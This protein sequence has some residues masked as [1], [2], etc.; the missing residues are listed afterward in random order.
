MGT[1]G[2]K[3]ISEQ[4][5][6]ATNSAPRPGAFPL[7]SIESR[8][9]ARALAWRKSGKKEVLRVEVVHIAAFRG[10]LPSSSRY[11]C[12]NCIIELIHL[13][14]EGYRSPIA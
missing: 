3:H 7:G 6:P 14:S 2:K 1:I 10:D 4:A 5:F 9:A 11:E 13:N 8:A 12:E